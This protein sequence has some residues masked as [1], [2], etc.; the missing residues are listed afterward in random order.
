MR[1]QKIRHYATGKYE[2]YPHCYVCSKPVLNYASHPMTDC[3]DINGENVG[4]I[5]LVLCDKCYIK[6][7]DLK[8]LREMKQYLE[9]L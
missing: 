5:L 2:N 4:D 8:T 1:N 7:E 3:K 6:T 9:K